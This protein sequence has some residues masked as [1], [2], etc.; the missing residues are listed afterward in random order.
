[1]A[2]VNWTRHSGQ[3]VLRHTVATG[4]CA[5]HQ[6][7]YIVRATAARPGC[8]NRCAAP[9]TNSVRIAG[10]RLRFDALQRCGGRDG[11]QRITTLGRYW[12]STNNSTTQ[13]S[14]EGIHS[15]DHMERLLHQWH[16]ESSLGWGTNR[17]NRSAKR[18]SRRPALGRRQRRTK[19]MRGERSD[20]W[21]LRAGIR[22]VLPGKAARECLPIKFVTFLTSRCLP[23][24]D[25]WVTRISFV[26]RIN[27]CYALKQFSGLRWHVSASPAFAGIMSL[28]NQKTG[29]RRDAKLHPVQARDQGSRMLFTICLPGRP[30]RVRAITAVPTA[31]LL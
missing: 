3:S 6:R 9:C 24:M 5:R 29:N 4:C 1:M 20:R 2:S 30:S 21:Q 27:R 13:E 23:A 17:R 15:G 11:L 10:K 28:V 18:Q 14:R 7:S 19:Q 31:R 12:N 16:L 25:S 8:D 22:A 26:S